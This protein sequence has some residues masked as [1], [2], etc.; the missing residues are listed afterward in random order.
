MGT[1]CL[2]NPE[3][4]NEGLSCSPEM[5]NVDDAGETVQLCVDPNENVCVAPTDEASTY[6]SEEGKTF[7]V[8]APEDAACVAGTAVAEGEEEEEEEE[9]PNGI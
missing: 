5:A 7:S 8:V 4:C 6:S 3:D 9:D 2:G 1:D